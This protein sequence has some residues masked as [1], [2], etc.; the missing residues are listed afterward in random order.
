LLTVQGKIGALLFQGGF[1]WCT[2]KQRTQGSGG[3]FTATKS[4]PL[5]S[6][7]GAT[8]Q[9]RTRRLLAASVLGNQPI[10]KGGYAIAH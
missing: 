9:H 5:Q 7:S 3:F 1:V 2:T 4:K 10:N 8:R 6:S